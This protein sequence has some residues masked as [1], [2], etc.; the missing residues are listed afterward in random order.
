MSLRVYDPAVAPDPAAWS[1]LDESTAMEL[2]AQH[3]RSPACEHRPAGNRRLHAVMHVIVENQAALGDE[4]PV[5]ATLARL[6]AEGLTRHEALHA[7]ASIVAEHLYRVMKEP[8]SAAP[9]SPDPERFA[10]LT[11][12]GWR[13]QAET[14]G[15]DEEVYDPDDDEEMDDFEADDFDEEDFEDDDFEEAH[16]DEDEED[17]GDDFDD[18]DVGDAAPADDHDWAAASDDDLVGALFT[19]EDTLPRAF[20]NEVLARRDRLT[21]QLIAVVTDPDSW[22]ARLPQW[23][24]P[25]HAT[26]ILG[27]IDDPAVD[28]AL[29]TAW[30]HAEIY[31]CDWVGEMI[32]PILGRRGARIRP[33]LTA[34]IDDPA[35]GELLRGTALLALAATT[36]TDPA[37]SDAV[38]ATIGRVL[39]DASAPSWVRDSAGHALL[40]FQIAAE[41]DAL[42]AAANAAAAAAEDDW[43]VVAFSVDEVEEAF[44]GEPKTD[45]YRRDWLAFYDPKRIAARQRRWAR[46]DARRKPPPP[47]TRVKVGRNDPCPC[48]SGE[49]YEKCCL[50]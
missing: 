12:E 50:E 32:P 28:A 29:F 31:D 16:F 42:V 21:G 40:D 3:H 38:F 17:F 48:G 20:V 6:V 11:A 36:L 9:P 43:D 19:A 44:T 15:D 26:F 46:E 30:R 5:A 18:E 45:P 27:A 34:I 23:W 24:A 35:E 41:R 10:A 1:A 22:H 47:V 37:G 8:H 13:A 2:V 14:A 33:V 4:L 49:K 39:R 25:I 7:V